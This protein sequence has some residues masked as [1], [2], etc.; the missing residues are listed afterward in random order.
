MRYRIIILLSDVHIRVSVKNSQ[1]DLQSKGGFIR[2]H[3]Q[4]LMNTSF[5]GF[6]INYSS[7]HFYFQTLLSQISQQ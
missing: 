3:F 7:K 1:F 6:L 4:V 2:I 5:G